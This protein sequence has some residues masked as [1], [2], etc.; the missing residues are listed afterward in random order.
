M[1][2]FSP[3]KAPSSLPPDSFLRRIRDFG[4]LILFLWFIEITDRLVFGNALQTHGIQPRSFS[5][6][7]GLIFAPFLHAGWGHLLGN[8]IS[9]LILGT[10]ILA[11]G[12]RDLIIVSAA[13]ALVAGVLVWLIGA[14]GTNHIG[15][16]S[17]VFGYLAFLFASGFYQRTPLTIIT[18]I[19]VVIFYGGTIFGILPSGTE[20]SWEGH[21]GGALGGFLVAR[22]RRLKSPSSSN[23]ASQ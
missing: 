9:L 4:C 20:I 11:W 12:W 3:P 22:S 17:L 1:N 23:D 13:S 5:H 8:S 7:E 21:L 2:E 19:L 16:S 10:A 14:S 18:S 15:A 6:F